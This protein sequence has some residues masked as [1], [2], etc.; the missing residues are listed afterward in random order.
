MAAYFSEAGSQCGHGGFALLF[1]EGLHARMTVVGGLQ[2]R[3]FALS[4]SI[5]MILFVTLIESLFVDSEL[6]NLEHFRPVVLG[7]VWTRQWQ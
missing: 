4:M 3:V 1:I 7:Q 6:P 2:S 5:V